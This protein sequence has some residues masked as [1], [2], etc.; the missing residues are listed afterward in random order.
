MIIKSYNHKK[1]I[2]EVT[3]DDGTKAKVEAIDHRLFLVTHPDRPL[4]RAGYVLMGEF[5]GFIFEDN[6]VLNVK[7]SATE[8]VTFPFPPTTNDDYL[9]HLYVLSERYHNL[10]NQKK[11][12]DIEYDDAL[13]EIDD[14]VGQLQSLESELKKMKT[15][16][17]MVAASHLFI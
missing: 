2:V 15:L 9:N 5:G 10:T 8:I 13:K 6:N 12:L 4:E 7:M 14:L 1:G 16:A 11:H 3:L 17:T